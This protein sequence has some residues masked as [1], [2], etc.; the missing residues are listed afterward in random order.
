MSTIGRG[1]WIDKLTNDIIKR[2][3][4]LERS[5]EIIN[6]ESGL[7][8]S[9]IPHIGSLG[10][11]VRA[12]GVKIA[13]ED[14]GYKS[15]LIAYSD[16]MDGLRKVPEGFPD[17]LQEEL[18]KPV[19]SID[20]PFGCHTSYGQHMSSLL[21]D[22]LDKLSID[23]SFKSATE[24]YKDG[25]LKNQTSKILRDSEIIGKKIAE[26][27][28]Q[29]KFEKLLPYYPICSN[30]NKIYVTVPTEFDNERDIIHYRCNDV[31]IGG[32]L[33]KGCGHDGE[34]KL[35]EGKGKL[36]WKVEFA[37]RWSALDIRFEA[38]GKDIEDS[39]KIN[40]WISGNIL[41][42]VHPFHIRY[43]MFLDKSGK[44]IS[45]SIGNVLTPQKWLEYG[46]PS[47]LLLL[48]FKRIS[49]ARS[50]SVEDIPTYM[51]EV[52]VV[53]DIYFN[54]TMSENK[55]KTIRMKG[56]Y[57]YVNHLNPPEKESIHLPYRLLVELAEIAPE[58]NSIE[59]ISKKLVE[60]QYVK[61]ID[62]NILHRIKLGINWA[63]DFKTDAIGNVEV[64]DEH[65]KPLSEIV[66][67]LEK[68]SDPDVI[69]S[70]IFEI[71]KSNDMKPR[72]L[73]QLIYQILLGSNKGPRLG[74]YII[75]AD[76]SKII[77]KIKSTIE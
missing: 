64:L 28:G 22:G 68:N 40:D 15:K 36:G 29:T 18:G 55:D 53:E 56:L 51:D 16:D 2:E 63:R 65:K 34:T 20:D 38:Y 14:N 23:Y 6:V 3:V 48:M 1:T 8:A 41:N 70:E 50:L 27:T 73:F 43:E 54:K 69:Q 52:D 39:V 19:S 35:S 10:D 11:A 9:G 13:L 75:D 30:C 60:Y 7:G 62:D 26:I 24:I 58:D 4:Q 42:H 66:T 25:I 76:K 49:G 33:I 5:T 46:T 47:S 44:K 74:K 72:V 12:Y 61:E 67:L 31:E 17:R 59:Y 77:K 32:N 71:A 37:A 45:K 21:L 57:E